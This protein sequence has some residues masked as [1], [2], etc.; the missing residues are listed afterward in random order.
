M[1]HYASAEMPTHPWKM[2]E[3]RRF[4]EDPTTVLG[5]RAMAAIAAVGHGLG[6]DYAGVDLTILRDGRVFVFEANAT[7]LAHFERGNGP[8][9][10][11]NPHVQRIVDAFE[12]LLADRARSWL[13]LPVC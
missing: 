13:G 8:L 11:R 6:L 5:D 3:E 2:E 10:Y 9:A 7:M 12:Q 1:V 4:L